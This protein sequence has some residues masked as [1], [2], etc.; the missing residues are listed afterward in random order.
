MTSLYFRFCSNKEI[1]KQWIHGGAYSIFPWLCKTATAKRCSRIGFVAAVFLLVASVG[2]FTI[3]PRVFGPNVF[4]YAGDFNEMCTLMTM[5]GILLGI[6]F[7][8]VGLFEGYYSYRLASDAVNNEVMFVEDNKLYY[9]WGEGE[10]SYAMLP[11]AYLEMFAA[12]LI[13]YLTT[14]EFKASYCAIIDLDFIDDAVYWEQER[15]FFI[16]TK[17][18]AYNKDTFKQ[19]YN[20]K[21]ID[22]LEGIDLAYINSQPKANG[23]DVFVPPINKIDFDEGLFAS[24]QTSINELLRQLEFVPSD[25]QIKQEFP[26]VLKGAFLNYKPSFGRNYTV[27][28]NYIELP[29]YAGGPDFVNII[30]QKCAIRNEKELI[31]RLNSIKISSYKDLPIIV[32]QSN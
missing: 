6:L 7:G 8:A 14:R 24:A 15:K 28:Q 2:M 20:F 5:F 32:D 10:I 23:Q 3:L 1:K 17:F 11:G 25:D 16:H 4:Y 26:P 31:D 21:L 27:P 22:Y 18:L 9:F 19:S 29:I 13:Y 12:N 30:Q